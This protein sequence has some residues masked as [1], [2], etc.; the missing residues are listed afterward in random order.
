M[1]AL[2]ISDVVC[3]IFPAGLHAVGAG[4]RA[5]DG[6]GHEALELGEADG[7]RPRLARGR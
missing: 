2:T 5:H 1:N 4:E 7:L 6:A 3:A